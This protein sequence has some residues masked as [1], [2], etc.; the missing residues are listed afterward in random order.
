MF[1]AADNFFFAFLALRTVFRPAGF[2]ID[3][4]AGMDYKRDSEH[5]ERLELALFLCSG[6]RVLFEVCAGLFAF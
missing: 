5:V 4:I 1:F 6:S 3:P 2:S